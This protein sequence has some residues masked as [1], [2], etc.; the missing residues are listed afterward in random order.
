MI[1]FADRNSR[2]STHRHLALFHLRVSHNIEVLPA[3]P[4]RTY[5]Q[6]EAEPITTSRFCFHPHR[7]LLALTIVGTAFVWD[8][9]DASGGSE[10]TLCPFH[11]PTEES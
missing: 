7:S 6:W 10:L 8:Y 5:L 1:F 4:F 9:N 2:Q 3:S 11:T